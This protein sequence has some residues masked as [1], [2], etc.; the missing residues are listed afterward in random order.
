MQVV[1]ID[2]WQEE[3][4]ELVQG[5]AE[6]LGISVYEARQRMIGNGPAVVAS[7]AEPKRALALAEELRR[8]GFATVIVDGGALGEDGRVEVRRFRFRDLSLLIESREGRLAEIPYTEI[9]IL[10]AVGSVVE[11]SETKTFTERKLSIGK[12]L[13]TGGV[14]MFSKK[15]HQEK[16][17]VE[18]RGKLLYLHA[19]GRPVL[20]FSQSGLVYDGLGDAMQLSRELNFALLQSELRRCCPNAVFDDRLLNRLA[21][22]RLLGPT[23]NPE[24]NLDLAVKILARSLRPGESKRSGS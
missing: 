6:V 11:S 10:L 12:T 2:N 18:E 17:T 1:A 7:P 22:V 13:A 8:L 15:E 19:N 4:P 14:P 3:S 23:L 21:Q 20:V 5:L 24:D 16:H 9:A